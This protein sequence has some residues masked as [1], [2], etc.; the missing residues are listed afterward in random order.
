MELPFLILIALFSLWLRKILSKQTKTPL[1]VFTISF[2]AA[3]IATGLITRSIIAE[4]MAGLVLMEYYGTGILLYW[5]IISIMMIVYRMKSGLK[6][7]ILP[8]LFELLPILLFAIYLL[9][10]IGNNIFNF[11]G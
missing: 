3:I 4:N 7:K 9:Y 11:K 1:I 8:N 2:L 6:S 5:I 10:Y